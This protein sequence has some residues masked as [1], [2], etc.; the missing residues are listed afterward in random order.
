MPQETKCTCML[1]QHHAP[2]SASFYILC[3]CM[4]P[5]CHLL[6]AVSQAAVYHSKFQWLAG[7]HEKVVERQIQCVYSML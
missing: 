6:C 5:K 7:H 4:D 2:A 1:A 3:M